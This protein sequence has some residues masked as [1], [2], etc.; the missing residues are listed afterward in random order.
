MENNYHALRNDNQGAWNGRPVE[1]KVNDWRLMMEKT[2]NVTHEFDLSGLV[3]GDCFLG[4]PNC[5]FRFDPHTG[6]APVCPECRGNMNLYYVTKD[7]VE[8]PNGPD[9]R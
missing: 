6:A 2:R 8:A 7:D 5:W 4:C 9:Q 3:A 1:Y